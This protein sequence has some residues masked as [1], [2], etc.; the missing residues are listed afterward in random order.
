MGVVPAYSLP[1]NSK[2]FIKNPK[3]TGATMTSTIE[4]ALSNKELSDAI[5][6]TFFIIQKCPNIDDRYWPLVEHFKALLSVQKARA[7][8]VYLQDT[9]HD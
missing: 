8:A 5:A 9:S 3:T 7:T 4:P 1:N 2:L 6:Y